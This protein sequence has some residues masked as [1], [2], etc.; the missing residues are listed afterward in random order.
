MAICPICKNKQASFFTKKGAFSYF[1]CKSCATIFLSPVPSQKFIEYFYNKGY[2]YQVDSISSRRMMQNAGKIMKR[3]S[4]LYP[5]GKKLLDVGSGYGDFL[6]A[7]KKSKIDGMGIEP[8]VNLYNFSKKQKLKVVRATLQE[9]SKENKNLLFD[10][11]TVIHLIEHVRNPSK[12]VSQCLAHLKIE[13]IM[14]IETPNVSSHLFNAE[15]E[16]YTFLTPPDHTILFSTTSL[17][18]VLN[19]NSLEIIDMHTF[20]YPEHISP[21]FTEM[22]TSDTAISVNYGR[23]KIEAEGKRNNLTYF[24]G[25]KLL[26][27]L[28]TPL[29]NIGNK[30]SILA[31]Y[32]RKTA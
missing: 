32:V 4:N 20:S 2:P 23:K 29:L 13:G 7:I 28:L 5:S 22:Q 30:G 26:Y 18:K 6:S 11:I 9:F 15:G 10:F 14:Y 1:H 12:F 8:A 19:Q 21:L 25:N 31:C 24:L 3:M 17:R 27:P 16:N